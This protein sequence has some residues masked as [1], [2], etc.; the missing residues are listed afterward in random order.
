MGLVEVRRFRYS[1][2]SWTQWLADGAI[3]P[4]IRRNPLLLT[5][6]PLFV[7]AEL[8]ATRRLVR[9]RQFDAIHAHW[10][11]PQGFVA[12]I[13]KRRYGLPILTTAHGSDINAVRLPGIQRMKRQALSASDA[14]TT[15]SE[16]LRRRAVSVGAIFERTV[17]LPMGVD[18]RS[19][20][21]THVSPGLRETLAPGGGPL[22]LFVGRLAEVKGVRFLLEAMP[23]VSTALPDV[24]LVIVGD[25]PER[26]RLERLAASLGVAPHVTFTGPVANG[27]L[28]S[29]YA[30]A[31]VFVAPSVT[32]RGGDTESFGL[33]LAEAMASGCP[34]I[35]SDIGGV[36]DVTGN[37]R[38]A[39]LV[40]PGDPHALTGAILEMLR[41]RRLRDDLRVSAL[42]HVRE[43]FSHERL[44]AQYADIIERIAA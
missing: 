27:D 3:L 2:P 15:V 35:A 42:E 25:G 13:L 36:A 41:S 1:W 30:S 17:T 20:A 5:E 34:V 44:H 26:E 21:P 10:T 11:V 4:N 22:V 14:V 29:Y 37:G 24:R 8:V 38:H 40:P 7:A 43:R 28:P 12:S 6:V 19:F 33:T 31:D 18:T 16:E 39:V 23:A 32:A 9:E